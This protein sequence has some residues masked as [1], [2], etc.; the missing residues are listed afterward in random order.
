MSGNETLIEHLK[1]MQ[2]EATLWAQYHMTIAQTGAYKDRVIHRTGVQLNQEQLLQAT[3]NT[4]KT[5]IL[6]YNELTDKILDARA[7]GG[8][9]SYFYQETYIRDAADDNS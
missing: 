3:L 6:R 5:H 7:R 8:N 9:D 2:S 1:S 4:A